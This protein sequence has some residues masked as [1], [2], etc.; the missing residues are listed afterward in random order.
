MSGILDGDLG[1]YLVGVFS[2]LYSDGT[3]SYA[4]ITRDI[5]TGDLSSVAT[6]VACKL[7]VDRATHRMR[8]EPG[9]QASDAA[10]LILN[11]LTRQPQ[12]GDTV[13]DAQGRTWLLASSSIDPAQSHYECRGQL[14]RAS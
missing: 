8:D 11:T 10:I 3:L 6:T 4:T 9:Y 12:Q 2:G 1:S 5:S 13:T 7:Q 14:Q